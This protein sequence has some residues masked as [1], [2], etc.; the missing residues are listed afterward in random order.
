MKR[1]L[2]LALIAMT[3]SVSA[4]KKAK[5]LPS[6]PVV[7]AKDSILYKDTVIVRLVKFGEQGLLTWTYAYQLIEVVSRPGTFPVS[8]SIYVDPKGVVIRPEDIYQILEAP[9]K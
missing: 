1:L 4:Q 8:K 2:T 5:T 3:L 6:S 7:P 9:Q